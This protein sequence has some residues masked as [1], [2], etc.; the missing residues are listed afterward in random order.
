[1]ESGAVNFGNYCYRVSRE[2]DKYSNLNRKILR[3]TSINGYL[4]YYNVISDI[5]W[6]PQIKM[7]EKLLLVANENNMV[8]INIILFAERKSLYGP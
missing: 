5:Y 3:A 2:V 1:M 6:F 7:S 4:E 8:R